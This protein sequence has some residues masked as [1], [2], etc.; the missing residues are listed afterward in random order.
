MIN[1]Y[2]SLQDAIADW[3]KRADLEPAIPTFIS[4]AEARINRTLFVRERMRDVAG[5]SVDGVI[6]VPDDL[7]RISA[8]QVS[9]GS[10][11]IPLQPNPTNAAA[12]TDGIATG[13]SVVGNEIRLSGGQ[14]ADYRL[15]YY[16][17][18]PPLSDS[19]PQCWLLEKE[20][21]L[22]LYGALIEA[23]PYIQDDERTMVWATQF[24]TIL[25]DCMRSDEYARFGNAPAMAV[26]GHA[27]P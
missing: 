13:Y 14:D 27:T 10:Q 18:I 24:Q 22:Y 19:A 7:D 6:P 17:R 3:L 23:A 8:L 26:S 16:A 20:P 4:L 12:R 1:D 9:R 11:W 5:T 15:T 2:A 25:D 21:G